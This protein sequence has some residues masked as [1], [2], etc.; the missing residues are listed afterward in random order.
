[1]RG[2]VHGF[3][4]FLDGVAKRLIKTFIVGHV[5]VPEGAGCVAL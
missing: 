5:V 2:L 4:H 3:I 1:M